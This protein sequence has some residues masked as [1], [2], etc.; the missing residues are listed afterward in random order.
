MSKV[1]EIMMSGMK[2]QDQSQPLTGRDIILGHNGAG[3][4]TRAQAIGISL[5]G[6]VPGGGKLPAETAK[7]ATA[8][9]M[10]VGIK[11]DTFEVRRRFTKKGGK[12]ETSVEVSPSKKEKTATAKEQ[13]IE[14]ELGRFPAMLDFG[15]FTNLTDTKRRE[16]IYSLLDS[17]ESCTEGWED[18]LAEQIKARITTDTQKEADNLGEVIAEIATAL[19]DYGANTQESLKMVHT[20]AKE[21]VSY[22]KKERELAN[23]AAVKVSEQKNEMETTDRDKSK[24][25]LLLDK[26]RAERLELE[27]ISAEQRAMEAINYAQH[28]NLKQLQIRQEE[29]A[30][31]LMGTEEI[32]RSIATKQT[33]LQKMDFTQYRQDLGVQ[34]Q[35][36]EESRAELT[37]EIERR[38]SHYQ[39]QQ[40]ELT[41]KNKLYQTLQSMNGTCA[42]DARIPCNQ[43]FTN[44]LQ[45]LYQ[46]LTA[47]QVNIAE[48]K[49][50]GTAI[51]EQ[52]TSVE[53]ELSATQAKLDEVNQQEIEMHRKNSRILEEIAAL[54]DDANRHELM[55]HEY[56]ENQ[57]AQQDLR[58]ILSEQSQAPDH[59]DLAEQIATKEAQIE[60]YV[61]AL[62]KIQTAQ[63]AIASIQGSMKDEEEATT[64]HSLWK[65]VA[66][67]TG[68]KG[69]QMEL[70][71]DALDPLTATIQSKLDSMGVTKKFFFQTKDDAEKE[72]FQFG[73]EVDGSRRIFNAL[74]TGE[75]LLVLI[76]LMTTIIEKVNPPLKMLVLDNTE[77]L[78]EQNLMKVLWGLEVAGDKLDNIVF[79]GVLHLSAE[80]TKRLP[81]WKVWRL[82]EEE[83][84]DE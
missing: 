26:A 30:E 49:G 42:I 59:N 73:W 76:A 24:I 3:K 56:Q 80:A 17:E 58:T 72:V 77:N 5:L 35:A 19:V 65:K 12:V 57:K 50:A 82:G 45:D 62:E 28:E 60:G 31:G 46:E 71:A 33:F 53:Q 52:L 40:A 61:S 38:R 16:F 67:V 25:S 64:L 63:N 13:R 44:F 21:Q 23:S 81:S 10:T 83:E 1:T 39:A 54:Q 15:E 2:G 11:T 27:R 47:L 29:L 37:A 74:S 22:W 69:L 79:I 32:G 51:R 75:Q 78:D 8:A 20:Q 55:V 48:T 43:N 4:T 36:C 68:P 9:Q 34:R 84:S 14:E 6:H 41:A 18:R 66:E 70:V 7:L